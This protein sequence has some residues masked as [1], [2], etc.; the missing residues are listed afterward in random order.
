MKR[1]LLLTICSLLLVLVVKGQNYQTVNPEV[2]SSFVDE[3]NHLSFIRIDSTGYENSL[4]LYPFSVNQFLFDNC[5]SPRAGSWIGSEIII[6]DNGYNIFLNHQQDSVKINTLA[7]E[8]DSWIAYGKP[9]QMHIVASII[10]HDVAEFL[11]LT[12]SVKVIG[13]Q[14]NDSDGAPLE[15]EINEMQVKISKNHGFIQTLNFYRFP[16]PNSFYDTPTEL[17]VAGLSE[18]ET[19]VQNFTWYDAHDFQPGD[20]LHVLRKDG[21]WIGEEDGYFQITETRKVYEYLERS[22]HNDSIVLTYFLTKLVMKPWLDSVA[23]YTDTLQ[24]VIKPNPGFDKLPGE[25]DF[26]PD[27]YGNETIYSFSNMI[28]GE[29]LNKTFENKWYEE[30]DIGCWVEMHYDGI[31]QSWHYIKGLGGPYYP[32]QAL[33]GS[34]LKKEPVYYEKNGE[35]WGTPLDMTNVHDISIPEYVKV[36]PNPVREILTV[37]I[38]HS[39]YEGFTLRLIDS[40]GRLVK[41]KDLE[42]GENSLKVSHIIPGLYFLTISNSRGI[43]EARKILVQ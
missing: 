35:T 3:N 42:P 4:I 10:E 28:T 17:I 9:G 33:F 16:E 14:V 24:E 12:D 11:G 8:G 41:S 2:I 5:F 22:D 39:G 34:M 25:P 15:S 19:G 7:M 13:F 31:P 43:L 32:Y 21:T 23:F 26:Q 20:V 18:P 6:K 30:L 27:Y 1:H 29:H 40:T 38:D 37:N 36:Y